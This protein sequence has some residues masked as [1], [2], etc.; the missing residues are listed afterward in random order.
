MQL[1]TEAANSMVDTFCSIAND[2]EIAG[3]AR[4]CLLEIKIVLLLCQKNEQIVCLLS[5]FKLTIY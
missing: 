2:V 5:F 4:H 1:N 3:H